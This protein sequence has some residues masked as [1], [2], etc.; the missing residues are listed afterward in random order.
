MKFK[1]KS[2]LVNAYKFIM[3]PEGV[4]S[5]NEFMGFQILLDKR[6]YSYSQSLLDDKSFR[7]KTKIITSNSKVIEEKLGV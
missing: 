4:L 3:A 6:G 7:L 2:S 5:Y 1:T